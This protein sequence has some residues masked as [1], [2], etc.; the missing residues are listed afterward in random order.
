[1]AAAA[2][3]GFVTSVDMSQTYLDW[4]EQNFRLNNLKTTNH[5]FVRAD[6][7][8]YLAQPSHEKYDLILLDPPTFSNSKKMIGTFE[9][10]RDQDFLIESC[11]NRL[12]SDGLL[13]FSNNKR[14]FRLSNFVQEKFH[15][16]D[17]TKQSIPL[18]FHNQ[19]I[20][21]C[22]ELR[23]SESRPLQK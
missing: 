11:I 17:I 1:V 21:V 19:S 7:L 20:H 18:D 15:I 23:T 9:V 4:A 13:I 14:K 12:A 3:G 16:R 2:G 6:I 5:N 8:Q 10:E 22:F